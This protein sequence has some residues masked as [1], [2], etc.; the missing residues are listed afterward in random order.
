M[1]L[2]KMCAC[3][4]FPADRRLKP[5]DFKNTIQNKVKEEAKAHI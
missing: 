4:K 3:R 2:R 5:L 1:V